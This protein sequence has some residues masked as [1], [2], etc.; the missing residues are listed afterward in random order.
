MKKY[1]LFREPKGSSLVEAYIIEEHLVYFGYRNMTTK[2]FCFA[3]YTDIINTSDNVVDLIIKEDLVGMK[4]GRIFEFL[5]FC[6]SPSGH[7]KGL[8][9]KSELGS[10]L[11]L[12][13]E[14]ISCIYKKN[15]N[16]YT[17]YGGINNV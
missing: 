6:F 11:T 1:V 12:T 9:V 16:L 8:L 7:G 10:N 17:K 3:L 13:C 15:G 5:G 4:D 14:D 2:K